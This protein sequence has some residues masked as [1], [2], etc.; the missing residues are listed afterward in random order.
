MTKLVHARITRGVS[1]EELA[2]KVGVSWKTIARLEANGMADPGLRL[3][4]NCAL[5]L[6]VKLESLI[7]E[8]WREWKVF[9]EERPVPP[10]PE[11][12][13][14]PGRITPPRWYQDAV[15]PD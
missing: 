13:F 10:D 7:E 11:T 5:A 9:K 12:F 8:S 3:L 2:D 1:Q 6:N 14:A 4:N 15:T